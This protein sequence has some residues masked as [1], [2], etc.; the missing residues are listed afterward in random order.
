MTLYIVCSLHH[1]HI[2]LSA[3][4]GLGAHKGQGGADCLGEGYA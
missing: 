3:V 2:V 4:A 1:H